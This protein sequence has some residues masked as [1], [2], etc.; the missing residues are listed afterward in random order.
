MRTASAGDARVMRTHYIP[1]THADSQTV[2]LP[3]SKKVHPDGAKG[4]PIF[5]LE[6][7]ITNAP[8]TIFE[9]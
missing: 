2:N 7:T 1:D 9:R 6:D 4:H 3:A 5:E 8:P